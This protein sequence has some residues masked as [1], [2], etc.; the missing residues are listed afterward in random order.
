MMRGRWLFLARAVWVALTALAL[1]AFGATG[2][3]HQQAEAQAKGR[4]LPE[5]SQA[6][7]PAGQYHTTEFE[8]SLSF[9]LTGGDWVFEGPS[10]TLGDPEHSDYLFIGKDLIAQMVGSTSGS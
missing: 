7:L 3:E 4:P 2:G 5:Y 10:G 6:S 9:R 1:S 8:P